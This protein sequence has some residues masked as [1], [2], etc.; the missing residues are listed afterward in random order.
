MSITTTSGPRPELGALLR[1]LRE[2]AGVTREEAAAVIGCT[3]SKIGDLELARSN[4]KPAET[5][6]LLEKYR[7]PAEKRSWILNHVRQQAGRKPRGTYTDAAPPQQLRR[8]VELESQAVAACYYSAEVI[9]PPLQTPDYAEALI[10]AVEPNTA[11]VKNLANFQLTRRHAIDRPDGNPS[12][13]YRCFLGEAILHANIGGEATMIEQLTHLRDLAIRLP[14]LELRLVPFGSSIHA[15]LG[16]STTL[17]YFQKPAQPRLIS[18][19]PGHRFVRH[20]AAPTRHAIDAFDLLAT[21][22]L[23]RHRTVHRLA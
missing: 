23:N 22:A 18:E 4:P 10:A 13:K 8:L 2:E 20:L 14:N 6:F 12:L 15:L 7:V 17:Y 11:K 5:A 16:H 19:V 3:P 21:T 9:P 1:R